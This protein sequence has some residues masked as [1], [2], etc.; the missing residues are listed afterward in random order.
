MVRKNRLPRSDQSGSDDGRERSRKS[1]RLT[2]PLRERFRMVGR[3]RMDRELRSNGMVGL[4]R[5]LT[6]LAFWL[7][8]VPPAAGHKSGLP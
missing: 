3:Q 7:V 1:P 8:Q 4:T 5:A 6:F 2:E